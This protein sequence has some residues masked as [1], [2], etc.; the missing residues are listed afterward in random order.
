MNS[1]ADFGDSRRHM[2]SRLRATANARARKD[3]PALRAQQRLDGTALIHRSVGLRHLLERQR[4]IKHLL[5]KLPA[6]RTSEDN[7]S[8][9]HTIEGS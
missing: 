9:C 1:L 2:P 3:V 6:L 7:V 5:N 4:Q 8:H